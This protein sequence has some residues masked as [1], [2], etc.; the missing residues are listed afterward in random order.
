MRFQF[1]NSNPKLRRVTALVMLLV[2]AL[3]LAAPG[4]A[5]T[6]SKSAPHSEGEIPPAAENTTPGKSAAEPA[7][8]EGCSIGFSD[9]HATDHYYEGVRYLYC[10]GAIS[11]YSDNTFRPGN[12]TTRGQVSKIV[13]LAKGWPL[14]NPSNASFW[15]VPR[16]STYYTYVETARARG[17]INGYSDGSFRLSDNV[18]RGQLAKIVSTAQGWSLLD[19]GTPSFA[20][21]PRGSTF[22]KYVETV[23]DRHIIGGYSDNTFRPANPATRGQISKIVYYAVTGTTPPPPPPPPAGFQLTPQE[24][25]MVNLINQR[26]AAMSLPTLRVNEQLTMAS[27]RHSADIGPKRL[28]QHDGTD[29]SSPWSRAT[30][31]GYTGFASGEVVACNFTTP[32]GAVDGWWNSPGHYGLLVGA[33]PNEIGCGWWINSEGYGWQ[34]CLVGSSK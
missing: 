2:A 29:G 13:V 16:G 27:R 33:A 31:A 28:C 21:V 20:D 4:Y 10:Q 26:R 34:T 32:L 7:A 17:L 30:D 15:D 9:V 25:E 14:S 11:G 24:Q 6:E 3:P 23:A 19:P 22:Y 5:Q 12:P 1:N 8:P 18:S